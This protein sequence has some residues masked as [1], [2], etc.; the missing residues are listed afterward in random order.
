MDSALYTWINAKKLCFTF[1]HSFIHTA[2]WHEKENQLLCSSL[3]VFGDGLTLGLLLSL[4]LTL[5]IV[6]FLKNII[7][8]ISLKIT[9]FRRMDL[10]SSSGKK[11]GDSCS[12]GS[13]R[14][15]YCLFVDQWN[16]CLPS[17]LPEDERRSL[18]RKVV[19]FKT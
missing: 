5:K 12:V 6:C 7:K 3:N 8:L 9:T 14:P 10:P 16:R 4:L 17:F 19:I 13:G 11:R 1:T 15:S 18:L 2:Q